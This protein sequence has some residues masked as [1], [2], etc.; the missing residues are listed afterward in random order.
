MAK[1]F[2]HFLCHPATQFLLI[3]E[4]NQAVATVLNTMASK[5]LVMMSELRKLRAIV[6][7]LGVQRHA[8]WFPS[9]VN[10]YVD[11]LFRT[12][13]PFDTKS[14]SYLILALKYDYELDRNVFWNRP[15]EENL[16]VRR[17]DVRKYLEQDSNTEQCY[18]WTPPFDL[19]K[20]VVVKI[21]A[22]CSKEVFVAPHWPNQD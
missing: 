17:N 3:H 9:A 5:S 6:R 18:P 14:T 1:H 12:W 7:K 19:L 11:E 16:T 10:K 2:F 8:Q 15:L 20:L 13:L 4:S 22:E 21:E